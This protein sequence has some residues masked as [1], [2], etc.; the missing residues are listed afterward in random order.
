M[1]RAKMIRNLAAA[2][3]KLGD[4][5]TEANLSVVCVIESDGNQLA[6]DLETLVGAH[7]CDESMRVCQSS[8]A[9]ISSMR[10]LH[11]GPYSDLIM[12]TRA[13]LG[14]MVEYALSAEPAIPAAERSA[15]EAGLRMLRA[16]VAEAILQRDCP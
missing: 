10:L 6:R 8:K 2:A 11:C 14:D 13:L 15:T 1:S 3:A 12:A 7:P 5:I 4:A 9:L 16:M